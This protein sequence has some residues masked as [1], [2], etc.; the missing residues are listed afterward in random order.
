[1]VPLVWVPKE[2][3]KL[4][5][6]HR[7]QPNTM[8][9]PTFSDDKDDEDYIPESE[10]ELTSTPLS[11]ETQEEETEDEAPVIKEGEEVYLS[12]LS[13]DIF[14]ASYQGSQGQVHGHMGYMENFHYKGYGRCQ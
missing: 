9:T 10:T 5:P 2:R 3:V 4:V 13:K 8:D 12:H 14:K 6:Y 1:M 7:K 11:R